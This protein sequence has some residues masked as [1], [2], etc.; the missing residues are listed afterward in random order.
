VA[1]K[2]EGSVK[3]I[4][5]ATLVFCVFIALLVIFSSCVRATPAGVFFGALAG[6]PVLVHVFNRLVPRRK[7]LDEALRRVARAG[8]CQPTEQVVVLRMERTDQR[9]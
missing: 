1:L 7:E 8:A 9:A 3:R 6:T 4:K 2:R 5:D